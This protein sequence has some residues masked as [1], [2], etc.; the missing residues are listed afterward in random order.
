MAR[1]KS[2]SDTRPPV[3]RAEQPGR[4]EGREPAECARAPDEGEARLR[5]TATILNT[6]L[7]SAPALIY[8]KDR[9]G[10]MIVANPRALALI[11]RP[12]EEVAGRRD[13]EFLADAR[14]GSII[15][16]TDRRI[17][18]QGVT[19][20]VEEVVSS[21]GAGPQLW[22]STK[23]PMR[24]ARGDVT[25]LVGVSIDITER[26]QAEKALHDLNATLEARIAERTRERDRAWRLSQNLL[27]VSDFDGVMVAVSPAWTTTLGWREDELLGRRFA[28]FIHPDDKKP[29]REAVAKVASGEIDQGFENRYLHKDG[30]YRSISWGWVV[31]DGLVYSTGRDLTVEKQQKAALAQAEARLIQ[32]RKM[33]AIGQL[34]GGIA[35][36]FNNMLQ[37]I[38]GSLEM[39]GARIAQ[40]DPER[41]ARYIEEAM[42][43]VDRASGL[44]H[45]LLA[46]AR[47]QA[48][49]PKTVETHR[50]M[51][52]L[53]ELIR[54]T[55]GPQIV[56][57]V[58]ADDETW[59]V[60][61]DPNQLESALINLSIN[62]RDAMPKGGALTLRASNETLTEADLVGR[63]GALPG[64]YVS[65]AVADT[66]A[67]MTPDV[68]ARAFEPFFTTKPA[69]QGTGLGL[70]QI[71]GFVQQSGG[72]VR[73]DSA[74]G[75]GT[76]VRL[77]LPRNTGE[78]SAEAAPARVPASPTSRAGTVLIVDDEAVVRMMAAQAVADLGCQVLE[79]EDGPAALRLLQSKAAIDMLVTDV[80]LPGLNGRQLADAA[81]VLR[82]GLPVLLITGYAGPAL[83]DW[84]LE[85]GME[86]LT[87]P[88]R[89]EDLTAKVGVALTGQDG[90]DGQRLPI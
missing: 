84:R 63:E 21:P 26:K 89:L 29:T 5:Q 71:Y 42:K 75:A 62:A 56:V 70:S 28:K 12:W 66:G 18:A 46:F 88:F 82:P 23:S 1:E 48:L 16:E 30:T 33:E 77:V 44:T 86:V 9:D 45:R 4:E 15:E 10:R 31:D 61:C 7:T 83:D 34:T 79:A 2:T 57:D 3:T 81:R 22:L 76:T 20:E 58:V 27:L 35:H 53:A 43:A 19:L 78:T 6:I 59:M 52:N 14:Q 74:P 32:S 51:E 90:R 39:M 50:L 85:A 68:A 41:A 17:M 47:R 38:S 65:I 40:G 87:K 8:A 11:G 36:D 72:F 37:G 54:R 55:V 13:S 80:G 49:A 67:G 73:L 25:G 24:D 64:E 60:L 69:G